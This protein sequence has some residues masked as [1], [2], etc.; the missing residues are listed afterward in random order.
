M[1]FVKSLSSKVNES[2]RLI[3]LALL[4]AFVVYSNIGGYGT[5][6][7][8]LAVYVPLALLVGG[9]AYLLFNQKEFAAHLAVLFGFYLN[10]G[11][12]LF[13]QFLSLRFKPFGFTWTPD[14]NAIIALIGFLYLSLM[15]ISLYFNENNKPTTPR[16]DL[17]VVALTAGIFFYIRAG[18]SFALGKLLLPIISLFFGAPIATLL[19][20]VAGV[21]E[22]PFTFIGTLLSGAP[23]LGNSLSFFLYSLFAF[24]LIYGG[25]KAILVESKPVAVEETDSE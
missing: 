16:K 3:V 4:L 5:I 25:V 22:Y 24:Y 18:F 1:N 23:V 7:N 14:L 9:V 13:N 2:V 17:V 11:S 12:T 20:L 15:V 8:N 6:W 21:G 10:G 19:F